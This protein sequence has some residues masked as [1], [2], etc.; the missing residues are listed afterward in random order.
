M[1]TSG[2][3]IWFEAINIE[4]MFGIGREERSEKILTTEENLKIVLKNFNNL[5]LKEMLYK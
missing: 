2:N 4:L 1:K 3:E 5:S